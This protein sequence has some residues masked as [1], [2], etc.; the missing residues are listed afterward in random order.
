MSRE[1]FIAAQGRI[2]EIAMACE[3]EAARDGSLFWASHFA[4]CAEDASRAAFEAATGEQ[5]R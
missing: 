1:D 5:D 2:C 4:Q 3:F